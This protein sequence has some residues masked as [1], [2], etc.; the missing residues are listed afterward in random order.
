MELALTNSFY[1]RK[2]LIAYSKLLKVAGVP[3]GKGHFGKEAEQY[4]VSI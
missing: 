4:R 3:Q 2:S 1:C